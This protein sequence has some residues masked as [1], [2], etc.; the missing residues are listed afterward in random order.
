[1]L[2]VRPLG[3]GPPYYGI[4][5]QSPRPARLAASTELRRGQRQVC[6]PAGIRRRSCP[7]AARESGAWPISS[8]SAARRNCRCPVTRAGRE[9]Q[10]WHSSTTNRRLSDNPDE[11]LGYH[12]RP[13]APAKC[14]NPVRREAATLATADADLPSSLYEDLRRR[15]RGPPPTRQSV[16]L[17]AHGAA[18]MPRVALVARRRANAVRGS[19]LLLAHRRHSGRHA[20]RLLDTGASG[21]HGEI[22][23][24]ATNEKP[25]SG[26]EQPAFER[27]GRLDRQPAWAAA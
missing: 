7:Q 5:D 17:S 10:C 25:G 11:H 9:D 27:A 14:L 18:A 23:A 13:E 24:L 2:G 26:S 3:Q 19:P 21:S 15:L 4:A 16:L 1:M 20:W 22:A 6:V 8:N 12:R